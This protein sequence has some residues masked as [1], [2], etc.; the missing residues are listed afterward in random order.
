VQRPR[1]KNFLGR[2]TPARIAESDLPGYFGPPLPP[3]RNGERLPDH[4]TGPSA[5]P[6]DLLFYRGEPCFVTF[7]LLW[8]AGADLRH[9]PLIQRKL[10][11]R[12]IIRENAERILY[13]GHVEE[14][15]K[16]LFALACHLDLEGVVAKRRSGLYLSDSEETSWLKIRNR[17]Y[18]QMQGRNELFD[19]SAGQR[20]TAETDGWAGCVLACGEAG[21]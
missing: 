9:L 1:Q 18:S 15:G 5:R 7:D 6:G 8:D 3:P 17:D 10:R 14:C 12:S 21:M 20:E 2:A 19:R 4:I 16:D 13:A 11:L